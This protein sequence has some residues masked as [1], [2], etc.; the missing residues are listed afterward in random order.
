MFEIPCVIIRGGTSKGVYLRGNDLPENAEKRD[1]LI[2]KLF[3][4]PDPRQIDGLGGGDPLTSKVAIISTSTRSDSDIAYLSGEVRLGCSEINYGIM[5][6]NLASG[7]GLAAHHL[8]MI[9]SH[10]TD[11]TVRIYNVNSKSIIHAKYDSFSDGIAGK[12]NKVNLTFLSRGGGLPGR[13]YP[14]IRHWIGH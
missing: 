14:R 9:D 8:N 11:S 3:G 5:C 1:M 2:S 4:S 6:G 10:P 7:V 12:D 13:Y